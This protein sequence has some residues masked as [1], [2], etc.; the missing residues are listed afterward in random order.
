MVTACCSVVN[1]DAEGTGGGPGFNS[2]LDWTVTPGAQAGC[3]Q[4]VA[5]R[6]L[7]VKKIPC[8]V[9]RIGSEVTTRGSKDGVDDVV[10]WRATRW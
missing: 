5:D 7:T 1:N 10:G 6:G 3:R 9:V 4:L 2:G 8:G